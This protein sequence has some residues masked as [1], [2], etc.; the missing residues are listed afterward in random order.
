MWII[1]RNFHRKGAEVA[2]GRGAWFVVFFFI[3]PEELRRSGSAT[4]CDLCASAVKKDFP[5]P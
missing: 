1:K 5:K 2:E 3:Y 4:L